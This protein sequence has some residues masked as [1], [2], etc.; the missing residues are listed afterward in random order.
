MQQPQVYKG[1]VTKVLN[2]LGQGLFKHVVARVV[3]T[4]TQIASFFRIMFS[5]I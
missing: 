5:I 4:W 2:N 1:F 3:A